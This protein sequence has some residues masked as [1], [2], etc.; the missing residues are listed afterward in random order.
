[1]ILKKT[2]IGVQMILDFI[3]SCIRWLIVF[4]TDFLPVKV[5]RDER[6]TPFLYRYHLFT[7]GYDGPGLCIHHFVKSDPDRGYHDHPWSSAMSFIL[8]GG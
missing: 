5:I 2:H 4:I 6:G 8:C 1:M 3:E 7:L